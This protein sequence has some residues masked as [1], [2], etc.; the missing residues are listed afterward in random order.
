MP[1]DVSTLSPEA[2]RQ[3]SVCIVIPTQAPAPRLP[4]VIDRLVAQ[5]YEGTIEIL[6]VIDGGGDIADVPS[7]PSLSGTL[8]RALR[9]IANT[10]APGL[11]GARRTGRAAAQGEV[12]VFCRDDE[13]WPPDRLRT[14]VLRRFVGRGSTKAPHSA[15]R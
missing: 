15:H 8:R 7:P 4:R 14:V 1:D 6:V 10:Q 13:E 2:H 9:T 5:R 3:P 12:V 11:D